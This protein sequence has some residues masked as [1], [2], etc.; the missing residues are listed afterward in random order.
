MSGAALTAFCYK[1]CEA[2]ERYV[3]FRLLL[4]FLLSSLALTP[5][6][7]GEKI[8]AI[9]VDSCVDSSPLIF[10][11]PFPSF[12]PLSLS[13]SFLLFLRLSHS[14]N[15]SFLSSFRLFSSLPLSPSLPSSSLRSFAK[16]CKK[17]ATISDAQINGRPITHK[18]PCSLT[19]LLPTYKST[20]L[21]PGPF[22][23]SQVPLTLAP[24]RAA[25]PERKG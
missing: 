16:A 3:F 13:L 19:L 24:R 2:G 11:S 15:T 20:A 14:H 12:H 25:A 17:S 21:A 8:H 7:L 18:S 23:C 22:N 10:I 4:L 1:L 6:L 9:I 5:F